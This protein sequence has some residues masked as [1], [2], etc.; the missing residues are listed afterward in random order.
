[1][2]K[3]RTAT[4]SVEANTDAIRRHSGYVTQVNPF[5]SLYLSLP[6][7]RI[8]LTT[9]MATMV[10]KTPRPMTNGKFL[11]KFFFLRVYADANTIGGS[12]KKKKSSVLNFK[13]IWSLRRYWQ[14]IPVS[15]PTV[16]S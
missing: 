9:I 4:V 15:T 16:L 14:R 7:K 13:M 1:M 11:I 8:K 5:S 3:V 12:K 6:H 10:P 2:I